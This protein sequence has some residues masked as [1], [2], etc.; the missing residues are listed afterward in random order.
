M[1]HR[2]PVRNNE[3]KAPYHYFI[4]L[5]LSEKKEF[6]DKLWVEG[7]D[8]CIVEVRND[9]PFL[10]QDYNQTI[11]YWIERGQ[12]MEGLPCYET[13]EYRFLGYK[14]EKGENVAEGSIIT[15]DAVLYGEWIKAD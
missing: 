6:L 1:Q 4:S 15:E 8:F 13:E 12:P 2:T 5:F 9:A 14:N 7:K 10:N 3:P 11:Y